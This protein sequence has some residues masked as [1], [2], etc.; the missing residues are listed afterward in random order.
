MIF[1]IIFLNIW[2]IFVHFN[3]MD[4][5]FLIISIEHFPLLL[6]V[7]CFVF[8]IIYAL[9]TKT[10][11]KEAASSPCWRHWYYSSLLNSSSMDY[12]DFSILM[13]YMDYF[14]YFNDMGY[15]DYI[16]YMA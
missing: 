6:W 2:I 8:S 7:E 14:G 1:W 12:M 3:F 5:I 4:Y 13:D 10:Q 15:M 11:N 16:D 9:N